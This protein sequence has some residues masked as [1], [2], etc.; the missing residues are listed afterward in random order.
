MEFNIQDLSKE[1]LDRLERLMWMASQNYEPWAD[2]MMLGGAGDPGVASFPLD[3]DQI[4]RI[5]I[6]VGG[7]E[8]PQKSFIISPEVH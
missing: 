5:D 2:M 8:G 3:L 7:V 6:T 4:E 1:D